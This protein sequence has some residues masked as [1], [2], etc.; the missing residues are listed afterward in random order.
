M[1]ILP[2]LP[3][4]HWRT[5][6]EDR[7]EVSDFFCCA[8]FLLLYPS[9][10]PL[11]LFVPFVPV[12]V[13]V[14]SAYSPAPST[15]YSQPPPPQR[16]VTALKPLAPSVSTSYNIYPVST[17]VQ[18]PPT[19]ISSYTLGSSFGSTVPA[20]TYSGRIR[21]GRIEFISNKY[22]LPKCLMQANIYT[23]RCIAHVYSLVHS[24]LFKALTFKFKIHILF[25]KRCVCV[26]IY[27]Y[28]YIY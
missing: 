6:P 5:V 27:I 20:T 13:G 14:K 3:K 28:I 23:H 15:V 21:P 17:S 12:S 19:T 11:L 16:Q 4:A 2:V 22:L 1:R 9:S 26:Y 18:Q 7:M 25:K 24:F 8:L 10:P